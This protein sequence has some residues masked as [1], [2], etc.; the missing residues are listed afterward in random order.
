MNS[1]QKKGRLNEKIQTALIVAIRIKVFSAAVCQ[2]QLLA[3]PP[4]LEQAPRVVLEGEV[5]PSL[6]TIFPVGA[7]FFPGAF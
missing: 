1:F 7:V 2:G 4:C 3:M 5:E 6:H